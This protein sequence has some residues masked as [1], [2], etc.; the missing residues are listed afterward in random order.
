MLKLY[1]KE[2]K[3]ISKIVIEG[4][5]QVIVGSGQ[6]YRNDGIIALKYH[7]M[8]LMELLL[9]SIIRF[10]EGEWEESRGE[11]GRGKKFDS[12]IKMFGYTQ[13]WLVMWTNPFFLGF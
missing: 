1:L 10:N 11:S 9:C 4:E 7:S 8:V 12:H 13:M 2:V 5:Y 3:N 6:R